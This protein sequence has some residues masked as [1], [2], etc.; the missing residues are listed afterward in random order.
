MQHVEVDTIV[1]GGLPV[2]ATGLFVRDGETSFIEDMEIKWPGGT[3]FKD[4]FVPERDME[5]IR[6]E[7][8]EAAEG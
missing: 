3:P 5:R 7:L 8:I 4:Q 6:E 2:L 1:R